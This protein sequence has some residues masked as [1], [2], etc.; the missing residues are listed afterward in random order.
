MAEFLVAADPKV[1]PPETFRK[2]FTQYLEERCL[3][4]IEN[5]LLAYRGSEEHCSLYVDF[6]DLVD[7]EPSLSYMLLNFP[8]LVLPRFEEA[9][10]EAQSNMVKH[11]SFIRKHQREGIV[12]KNCHV[13]FISLPVTDRS[14]KLTINDINS[15]DDVSTLI[16]I[17]G[18][19]VRTGGVR[20]LEVSKMYECQNPRCLLRFTVLG[21]P[22]QDNMLSTPRVCPSR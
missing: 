3:S 13:R 6:V 5:I 22:E 12:K 17:S 20:M 15:D 4:K 10:L 18:T 11:P 14:T 16:Q 1:G 19:I 9:I 21:D 8:A 7:F 2:Q